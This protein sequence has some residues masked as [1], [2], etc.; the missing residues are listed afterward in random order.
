MRRCVS[1]QPRFVASSVPVRPGAYSASISLECTLLTQILPM[2]MNHRPRHMA[3][4]PLMTMTD[5]VSTPTS[6]T[7]LYLD[8]QQWNYLVDRQVMTP[9]SSPPCR[10]PS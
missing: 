10:E 4:K 9:D 2:S 6:I 8:T 3:P 7:Y 1:K 5:D